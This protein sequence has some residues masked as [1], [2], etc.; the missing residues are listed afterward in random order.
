[1]PFARSVDRHSEYEIVC[2]SD[3]DEVCESEL[4]GMATKLHTK[5]EKVDYLPNLNL[6]KVDKCLAQLVTLEKEFQ[7]KHGIELILKEKISVTV[8]GFIEATFCKRCVWYL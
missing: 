7:G 2:A 3:T 5:F 6:R 8:D 1:M 4:D